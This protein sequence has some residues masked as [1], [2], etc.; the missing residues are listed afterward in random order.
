MPLPNSQVQERLRQAKRRVDQI[1]QEHK[2]TAAELA[3]MLP[4]ILA[5]TFGGEL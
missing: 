4:A 5:R 1:N 3:A 2:K